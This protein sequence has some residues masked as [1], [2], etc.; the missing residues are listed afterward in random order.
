[1]RTVQSRGP[2]GEPGTKLVVFQNGVPSYEQ[3]EPGNPSAAERRDFGDFQTLN[4]LFDKVEQAHAAYPQ[5][6]PIAGRLGVVAQNMPGMKT[7][8]G[9]TNLSGQLAQAQNALLY[10]RSGKAISEPE[11][12]RM[13]K[14]LPTINDKPEDFRTKLANSRATMDEFIA[15]R[16]SAAGVPNAAPVQE[17]GPQGQ[18]GGESRYQRYLRQRGGGQ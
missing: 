9:L 3:W 6:G 17:P 2:N 14:E 1:V 18:G 8:E 13:M 15:N 10:L 16:K 7:P 4:T 11:F 12:R 5:T